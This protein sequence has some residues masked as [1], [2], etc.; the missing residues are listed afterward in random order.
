[1]F[2]IGMP[3]SPGVDDLISVATW[4]LHGGV[5]VHGRTFDVVAAGA[6]QPPSGSDHRALRATLVPTRGFAH[7]GQ[8]G[9]FP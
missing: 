3:M 2:V 8:Q 6:V 9:S 7:P 1:V 5:D 4:N